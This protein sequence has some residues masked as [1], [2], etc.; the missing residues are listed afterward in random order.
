MAKNYTSHYK[1]QVGPT[2]GQEPVYLLEITH[3]QLAT[4]VR[5]VNDTEDLVLYPD[6]DL[7]GQATAGA[8]DTLTLAAGSS[9]ATDFYKDWLLSLTS[10]PGSV[11][12]RLISAYN[13]GTRVATVSP[14]WRTNQFPG[15]SEDFTNSSWVTGDVV[16]P[17]LPN[18]LDVSAPDGSFTA[19]KFVLNQIAGVNRS[20]GHNGVGTPVGVNG[21]TDVFSFYVYVPSS[22]SANPFRAYMF[23]PGEIPTDYTNL[24][25]LARDQWVRVGHTHTWGAG[26]SGSIVCQFH[27]NSPDTVGDKIYVWHPQ[28]EIGVSLGDYIKANTAAVVAPTSATLYSLTQPRTYFACAFRIQLPEDVSKMMPQV[29]LVIDNIGRELTQF[30]EQS[31]GGR[32]AQVTIRQVMR[33]T[34]T[35]IEQEYTL[36]LLNVRQTMLEVAGQLGY[37][38]YLD[39]PC[40][41]ALY[42]PAT[43]PGLF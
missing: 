40:L 35:V 25:A 1:E 7:T 36:S 38:N 24:N 37:E 41:P 9:G 19:C 5:L 4:P 13:G 26:T 33:D 16:N 42:T 20:F 39:A 15:Y 6:E 11:Q 31:F 34:P 17:K 23:T 2:T 28:L 29:P 3:P 30:L 22:N 18:T 21:R 8:S 27:A 32:G 12:D 10:G 43:A 14:R